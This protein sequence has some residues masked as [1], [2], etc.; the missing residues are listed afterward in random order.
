ML[1]EMAAIKGK[2]NW[3]EGMVGGVERPDVE[4]RHLIASGVRK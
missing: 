1:S 2:G 3:A 4:V